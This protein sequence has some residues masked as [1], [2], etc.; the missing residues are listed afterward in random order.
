M[1][2]RWEIVPYTSGRGLQ[3]NPMGEKLF[4]HFIGA[5]ADQLYLFAGGVFDFIVVP[6]GA[7]EWKDAW[8]VLQPGGHYIVLD[9]DRFRVTRKGDKNA[10]EAAKWYGSADGKTC[11]IVRYGGFGDMIQT[12]SVLPALKDLGFHITLFCSPDGYDIIRSDPHIDDFLIQDK[13]QVPNHE[14]VAFWDYWR[15]KFDRWINFSE[16]VEGT[17]LALPGRPNHDWPKHIRNKYLD[18]NYLEFAHELAGVKQEYH[19]RFYPTH[20]ERKWAEKQRKRINGRVILW[21]LSG[22]SVHKTWPYLDQIVARMMLETSDVHFVFVGDA[23]TEILE[24]GWQKEPRVKRKSGKWNIRET[25]AFIEYADLIIGP[26]TGVLNAASMLDVPKI[27]YL[28]HSSENN[29]TRDWV[30]NISLTPQGCNCYPCH[31]LHY[32]F[33]HCSRDDKTGVAECQAKISPESMLDAIKTLL[34]ERMAA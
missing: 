7:V 14:L 13:D 17:F 26:E 28:S 11:A 22:S 4:P 27:T 20:K 15:P 32:G 18:K 2:I 16:S 30:N 12:S 31:R 19:P 21:T 25:L 34:R 5:D 9:G 3:L 1:T 23:L 24:A 29:L 10:E 8:R 33:Q 6:K